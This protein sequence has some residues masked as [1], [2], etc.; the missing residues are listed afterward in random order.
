MNTRGGEVNLRSG[1]VLALLLAT[2]CSGGDNVSG[3]DA[4]SAS[5][6]A[7]SADG[8]SSAGPDASSESA[9]AP[10]PDASTGD[11]GDVGPLAMPLASLP[12]GAFNYTQ[13]SYIQSFRFTAKTA[14]TVTQLGYY[15]AN[16]TGKTQTF[17]AT[18]AGLYDLTT[19]T[20]LGS[21][22][23]QAS[24]PAIGIFR[25]AALATPIT[26]STTD[27]YAVAAVT[28]TNYYAAG[29]NFSGQLNPSLTWISFA[30]VGQDNLTT[31]ST[32]I[33]PSFF[34]TTTGDIGANFVIG[35]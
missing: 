31:T 28:G 8:A 21:V 24:D 17:Q 22:T 16:L 14:V 9:A 30:G 35:Q 7:S 11:A 20:L 2:A 10:G 3:G 13:G 23:V 12:S 18:P 19:H 27:T 34:W 29:F 5:A 15:D 32:L 25:F 26:L 6:D 4:G 33:E 1:A